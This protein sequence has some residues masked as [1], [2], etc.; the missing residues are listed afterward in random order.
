[1]RSIADWV[2]L[3]AS[4]STSRADLPFELPDLPDEGGLG[5][6]QL[7]GGPGQRAVARHGDEVLQLPQLHADR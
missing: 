6:S 1:V 5:D 3:S 4:T 7:G 2:V